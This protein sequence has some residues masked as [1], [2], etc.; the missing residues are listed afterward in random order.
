MRFPGQYHDAESGLHYNYF[1]YYDPAAARYNSPDPLG[2]EPAPNHH[3]YV[4]NPLEWIDLLGLAP[5][6]KA[7]IRHYTTKSGYNK[8]MGGGGKDAITLKAGQTAKGNPTAVYV[9]PMSPVDVAKKPGGFK[10]Y[11]GLTREKSEYMIEF[12]A[13]KAK[14]AG[15]LPGGR[16]HIWFSPKDVQIPRGSIKYHGP[17]SNWKP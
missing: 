5:A 8:I 7:I 16:S 10:S 12:E 14:F 3:A 17:T 11:L 6:C 1:R 4:S 15:R 2:L 13:D 9:T